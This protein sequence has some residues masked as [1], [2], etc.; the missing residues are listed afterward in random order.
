VA[1]LPVG[2]DESDDQPLLVGTL[3][4]I[5]LLAGLGIALIAASRPGIR[6]HPS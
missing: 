2:G 6:S 1:A 5:S 4:V 3:A